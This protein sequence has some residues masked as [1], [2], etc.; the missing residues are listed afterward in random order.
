VLVIFQDLFGGNEKTPTFAS[1]FDRKQRIQKL[2][3]GYRISPFF[4]EV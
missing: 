4:D 1:R 2:F 3:P